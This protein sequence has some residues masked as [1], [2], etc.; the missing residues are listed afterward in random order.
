MSYLSKMLLSFR[1]YQQPNINRDE[2]SI[3]CFTAAA[4]QQHLASSSQELH[5]PV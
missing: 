3:I 2:N 4:A 1:C 5:I